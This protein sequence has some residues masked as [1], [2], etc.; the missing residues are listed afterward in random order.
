MWVLNGKEIL[1]PGRG[2]TDASGVQHPGSWV[3]WPDDVKEKHGIKYVSVDPEPD[4]KFY[5]GG[6]C[7]LDGKW[8]A[9]LKDVDSVKELEI[10]LTKSKASRL[11]SP[12]DWQV[13]AKAER[14]R[15]ID[16]NVATYRAAVIAKCTEIEA[17]ITACEDMDAFQAL[18]QA[19]T[20]DGKS[21]PPI[22]DDWP[23]L[24]D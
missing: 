10:A 9:T 3:D 6:Q 19:R 17:A 22:V 4:P 20:V 16:S 18:F 12:S 24:G 11:L 5:Y 13:I 2:W 7:G 15:A 23:V 21:A 1:R 8:S 14:D